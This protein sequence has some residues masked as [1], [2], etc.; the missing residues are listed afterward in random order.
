MRQHATGAFRGSTKLLEPGTLGRLRLAWRLFRDNRVNSLKYVLPAV[1]MLYLV[2]PIDA[3]PDFLVGLDHVDDVGLMVGA[4]LLLARV[5][6]WLAPREVVD[7]H[8]LD[9]AGVGVQQDANA[10]EPVIEA[11]FSVNAS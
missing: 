5:L 4:T 11:R 8:V 9:L 1:I 7:E 3:I 2:S 6:P 10:S